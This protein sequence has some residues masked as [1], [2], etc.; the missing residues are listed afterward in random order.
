MKNLFEAED[1]DEFMRLRE[2]PTLHAPHAAKRLAGEEAKRCTLGPVARLI[3]KDPR[4][5]SARE[6][7]YLRALSEAFPEIAEAHRLAQDFAAMVRKQSPEELEVW[8]EETL[9]VGPEALQD[10]AQGLGDDDE[11]AVRA[12]LCEEWSSGQ[13]EGRINKLKTHQKQYACK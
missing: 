8:I 5:L 9:T 1:F 12:A 6:D 13:V 10:F 3:S 11:A 7:H 4:K 2:G